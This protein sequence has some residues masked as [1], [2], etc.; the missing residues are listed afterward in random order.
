ML[1]GKLLALQLDKTHLD[2][3]ND[4]A[5]KIQREAKR[6]LREHN[7]DQKAYLNYRGGSR[8]EWKRVRAGIVKNLRA[9]E[10][11]M[12][13][14]RTSA[15]RRRLR[16]KVD[17]DE[18]AEGWVMRLVVLGSEHDSLLWCRRMSECVEAIAERKLVW[19]AWVKRCVCCL[20]DLDN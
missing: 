5:A 20:L 15:R 1:K 18:E 13:R 12:K 16:L 4:S 2:H 17:E 9:A 8:N 7:A 19:S 3:A 11:E 14:C 10:A 6:R